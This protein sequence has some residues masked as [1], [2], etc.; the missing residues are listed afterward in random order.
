[1]PFFLPASLS[2]KSRVPSTRLISQKG[3]IKEFCLGA[4]SPG[5]LLYTATPEG[6][7]LIATEYGARGHSSV[8]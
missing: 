1:M 7:G 8:R 4:N 2:G 6:A 5:F 3:G